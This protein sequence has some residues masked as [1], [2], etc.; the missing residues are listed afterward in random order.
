MSLA[1]HVTQAEGFDYEP[2]AAEEEGNTTTS[3]EHRRISNGVAWNYG[4]ALSSADH[5]PIDNKSEWRRMSF[6]P[7]DPDP[8]VQPL[9]R[10]PT[11]KVSNARR[12][13]QVA[14]GY[15]DLLVD[16][17]IVSAKHEQTAVDQNR[18]C[19]QSS[20]R[21]HARREAMEL[22]GLALRPNLGSQ[23]PQAHLY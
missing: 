17:V 13:A 20:V 10:I 3:H 2:P 1:Q 23:Q 6:A 14:T 7:G 22:L 8:D 21:H 9:P 15:D 18:R 11:Y 12:F 4:S 16:P 19:S 5:L